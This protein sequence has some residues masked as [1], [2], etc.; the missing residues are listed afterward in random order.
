MAVVFLVLGIVKPF[1]LKGLHK[2]WMALAVI[3]GYFMTKIILVIMFFI[4]FTP[5]AF[6]IKILRKDILDLKIDKTEKSFWKD[7]MHIKDPKQYT[8]M[9]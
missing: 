6:L 7:Y 3:L 8:K 4:V 5:V 2:I 9:F 1:L